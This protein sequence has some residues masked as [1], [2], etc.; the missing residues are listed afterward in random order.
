[1][2]TARSSADWGYEGRGKASSF[3]E[4]PALSLM[5]EPPRSPT[6]DE[7]ASALP[8]P[9]NN[10][11]SMRQDVGGFTEAKRSK[12]LDELE[13]AFESTDY[14]EESVLPE[15]LD[16]TETVDQQKGFCMVSVFFRIMFLC[17]SSMEMTG[18]P[19]AVSLFGWFTCAL[20]SR[21]L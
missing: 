5:K 16:T 18:A 12:I 13:Q 4:I 9:S 20:V 2:P 21:V 17:T 10:G 15:E 1:M 14:E 8:G 7:G 19:T 6:L 3:K 11:A